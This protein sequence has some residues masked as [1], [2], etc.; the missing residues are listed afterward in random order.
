MWP[1]PEFPIRL[2]ASVSTPSPPLLLISFTFYI[3]THPLDLFA[4]V[5]TPASSKYHTISA[6]Q[7]V[8]VLS[9]TLVVWNS[10]PLHIR[11]VTAIDTF[12]SA[13]KTYLSTSKN[14][15]SLHLPDL[16]C[17][18]VCGVCGVFVCGWKGERECVC[19]Q[20]VWLC[21]DVLMYNYV[22]SERN[23]C[24]LIFVTPSPLLLHDIVKHL[25]L[26]RIGVWK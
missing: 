19:V 6:R 21:V 17:A 18:S 11:N 13:L 10:L 24:V 2:H 7:E 12:K 14:L 5:P 3:C 16:L 26:L 25:E 20:Q 22:E 4:P 8:I 23:I 1:E 15:I 9:L